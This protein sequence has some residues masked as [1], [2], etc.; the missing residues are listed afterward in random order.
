M[1][2]NLS[3]YVANTPT[4]APPHKGEGKRCSILLT[5]PDRLRVRDDTRSCTQSGPK[6]LSKLE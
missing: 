5:I 1:G 6:A 3:T 2:D 4:P